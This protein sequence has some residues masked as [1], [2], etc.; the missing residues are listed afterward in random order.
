MDKRSEELF[1]WI[2]SDES[3]CFR[4]FPV[5]VCSGSDRERQHWA[6]PLFLL[7]VETGG[8]RGPGEGSEEGRTRHRDPE[9]RTDLPVRRG[10]GVPERFRRVDLIGRPRF[11]RSLDPSTGNSL[12][13]RDL[14][15]RFV[16][17]MPI[18]SL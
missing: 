11:P 17:L 1:A 18:F 5:R 4:P 3:V 14:S 12:V 2:K 10:F 13:P 8:E 9:F 6:F 15:Q 16:D 7:R